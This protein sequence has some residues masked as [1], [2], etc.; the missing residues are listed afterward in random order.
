MH[1]AVAP[2]APDFATAV[3][4]ARPLLFLADLHLSE[5]IPKTVAAF[6]HFIRVTADG[7]DSVFILGDLFEFWIG[8]DM[9]AQPF[10]AGIASL[11]HTL[12]ERGIALYVMHGNR[13][14]LLG[15][16]FMKAAGALPL[17]D[18]FT[19]TAFG[20]RIVLAH[21]DALCTAD[22]G[23]QRFRRFARLALAQ[24]AFL[25]TPYAW[26]LKIGEK[27]RVKSRARPATPS[28]GYDVTPEAV[29]RLLDQAHARTMI[30]G[31]THLPARHAQHGA[32]RWV[33]PDW[34]LDHGS[35]RGG[36]LLVDAHGAHVR[37]LDETYLF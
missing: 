18:P 6:E 16:R 25:C 27:M 32:V 20:E 31:H 15:R 23:Y 13:D 37:P 14:F 11:L 29:A 10:V 4:T 24:K 36:Y 5:A 1:D 30:H 17:P 8:D 34:D 33:L 28:P 2:R 7:A 22:T 35:P 21:G 9:L 12:S 3:P 19:I 26:R